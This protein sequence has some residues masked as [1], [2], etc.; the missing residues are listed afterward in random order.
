MRYRI[1]RKRGVN[2][3]AI[4][5]KNCFKHGS[6]TRVKLTRKAPAVSVGEIEK[7]L[8]LDKIGPVVLTSS[9][10]VDNFTRDKEYFKDMYEDELRE[11]FKRI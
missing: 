2:M 1:C 10:A 9:G 6:C 3:P 5:E 7:S 8:G 4:F 11:L